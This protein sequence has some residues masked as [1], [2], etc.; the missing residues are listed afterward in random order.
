MVITENPAGLA[1]APIRKIGDI[2]FA[3]HHLYGGNNGGRIDN[4][5]VACRREY[6]AADGLVEGVSVTEDLYHGSCWKV[7]D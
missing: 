6:I 3:H 4:Y 1:T 7:V 2:Y 5:A